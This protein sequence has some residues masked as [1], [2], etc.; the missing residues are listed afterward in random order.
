MN[1]CDMYVW[2]YFSGDNEW[3]TLFI[4]VQH[5]GDNH[6]D[7]NEEGCKVVVNDHEHHRGQL[8][9]NQ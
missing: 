9:E 6:Q 5:L 1:A 4:I 7:D 3:L 2:L 8:V